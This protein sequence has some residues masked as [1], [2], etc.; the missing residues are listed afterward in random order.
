[1][2]IYIGNLPME[3][4]E[5]DLARIFLNYGGT[6]SVYM[7]RD[8]VNGHPLGMAFVEV[9]SERQG[10]KAINELNRTRIGDRIVIVSKGHDR[11]ERRK[12][13]GISK[14]QLSECISIK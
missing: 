12:H 8:K 3:T 1:M 9:A 14:C 5:T 11:T 7:P 6:L 4:S 2:Y 13:L 10:L